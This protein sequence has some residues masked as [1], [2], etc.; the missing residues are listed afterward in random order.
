[1]G[2]VV[3]GRRSEAE[4]TILTAAKLI[5]PGISATFSEGY[6][7]SALISSTW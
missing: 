7:W 3:T 1:M 5:S 2:I 6:A 4:R